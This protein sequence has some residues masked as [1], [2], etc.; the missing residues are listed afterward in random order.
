[1][2][3]VGFFRSKCLLVTADYIRETIDYLMPQSTLTRSST[4][5]ALRAALEPLLCVHAMWE[6]GAAAFGRVDE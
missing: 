5:T 3:I 1:M 4:L 2:V 6:G